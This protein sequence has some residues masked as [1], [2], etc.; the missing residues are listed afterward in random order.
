MHQPPTPDLSVYQLALDT[1]GFSPS[2]SLSPAT[3]TSLVGA[4]IDVLIEEKIAATIWVKPF[5]GKDWQLQLQRYH[6]QAEFTA[7]IYLCNCFGDELS[8]FTQ[9][10]SHTDTANLKESPRI[11]PVQLAAGSQLKQEYFFLVIS[12]KLSG[13]IAAYLPHRPDAAVAIARGQIAPV[14][15]VCTFDHRVIQQVLESLIEVVAVADSTPEE[16]LSNQKTLLPSLEIPEEKALLTQILLKQLQHTQDIIEQRQSSDFLWKRVRAVASLPDDQQQQQ[17]QQN[18]FLKRAAQELRTPLTNMKTA[19]SLLDSAQLHS[20]QRQR[21]MEVLHKEC[22][23]QNALIS[24]LLELIQLEN[25]S[26]LIAIV[27]VQLADVVPAIVSTYQPIAQEKGIQLGYTVPTSLPRVS[28]SGTWLQQ[29][30]INLLHNS[31]KF[32]PRGGQVR[33][34]ATLQGKYVQLA[35]NDTGLGIAPDEIP[36]IFESFYRGRLRTDYEDTSAGLGLTIVQQLL[37]CCGGSISV[38]SKLGKGSS[39]NVLLPIAS[40]TTV[41]N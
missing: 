23:R 38:T 2:L 31:L 41:A 5:P 39:F 10:L 19:L 17:Q 30:S 28:C 1:L 24:G 14:P 7:K 11:L 37:K 35:F 27:A 22:H 26:Q 4:T 32:T 34:L 6:Q 3:L 18:N 36:C 15:V 12:E 29:I 9:M 16:I 40:D 20:A 25:N 13:L 33:V 21:Y 8:D